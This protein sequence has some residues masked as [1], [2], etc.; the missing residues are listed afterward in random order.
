M[1]F[2]SKLRVFSSGIPDIQLDS[3]MQLLYAL[4]N[5]IFGEFTM[6]SDDIL[7]L[8]AAI[9]TKLQRLVRSRRLNRLLLTLISIIRLL[10]SI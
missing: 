1:K 3:V 4:K 2:L 8:L 6:L 9:L 10:N 7:L 5:L